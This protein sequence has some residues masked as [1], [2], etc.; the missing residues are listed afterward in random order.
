MALYAPYRSSL[1]VH[2]VQSTS[3]RTQLERQSTF[4][5]SIAHLQVK[6]EEYVEAVRK[7]EVELGRQ[8]GSH[9]SFSILSTNQPRGSRS[10]KQQ[11]K[12]QAK[13]F[14]PLVQQFEREGSQHL[15]VDALHKLL[16]M[17]PDLKEV[18]SQAP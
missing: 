2:I 12:S 8:R 4:L 9:T 18:R 7:L 6:L 16:K 5:S 1:S 3:Q 11:V 10:Y 15:L 14:V 17:F 13:Q